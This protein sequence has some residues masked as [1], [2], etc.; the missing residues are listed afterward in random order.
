[1][2]IKH[3]VISGGGP[4]GVLMYGGLKHLHINKVCNLQN[5][6]SIYCT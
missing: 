3:L 1:M 4:A 6:Q 2:I 5:I